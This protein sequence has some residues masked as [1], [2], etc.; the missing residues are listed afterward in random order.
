MTN[1]V[2]PDHSAPTEQSDLSLHCL[3]TGLL[4][5]NKNSRLLLHL[6]L[7]GFMP[8]RRL[9]GILHIEMSRDV[10]IGFQVIYPFPDAIE[11]P[12]QIKVR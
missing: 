3:S 10:A 8:G 4:A 11:T 5:V 12:F 2:G 1:S 9:A 6:T 7:Q